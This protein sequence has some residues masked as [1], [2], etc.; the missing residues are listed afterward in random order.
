MEAI[1]EK[2]KKLNTK[3][4]YLSFLTLIDFNPNNI[5]VYLHIALYSKH[6]YTHTYVHV[7]IY[8]YIYINLKNCYI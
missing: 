7:Y 3:S 5:P 8:I 2:K 1:F 4:Y 6:T